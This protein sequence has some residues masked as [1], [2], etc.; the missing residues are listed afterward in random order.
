MESLKI[1]V[2]PKNG[3]VER[4]VSYR[5]GGVEFLDT[6]DVRKHWQRDKS[7]KKAC[8]TL[9]IPIEQ[10]DEIAQIVSEEASKKHFV[11]EEEEL[12]VVDRD[13]RETDNVNILPDHFLYPKGMIGD[14]IK[15]AL[16]TSQYPQPEMCLAGAIALMSVITGRRVVNQHNARTNLYIITVNAARSGKD[17]I[18]DVNKEILY[19]AGAVDMVGPERV[20]S[21]A[22]IISWIDKSPEILFQLDEIGRMLATCRDARSSHLYNVATVLM[23]LFSSAGSMWKADAYAETKKTKIIDQ[24]HCVVFGTTT[25]ETLWPNIS[26][27]NVADGMI[28]RLLI[29]EG[30]GYV[31]WN[32]N[33]VSKHP[34]EDLVK[35]VRFWIEMKPG[36]GAG[37]LETWHPIP[38]MIPYSKDAG[39]RF[40]DHVKSINNKRKDETPFRAAVWSGTAE[41]TAKLALIHACSMS[42]GVPSEVGINDI[43]WAVGI[44]NFLTRKM[45]L[46][47]QEEVSEN[48][49][50]ARVKK[51]LKIIGNSKWT[52]SEL[53]KKLQWLTKRDRTEILNDMIEMRLIEKREVIGKTKH[54]YLY[55]STKTA[56]R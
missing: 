16:E 46:R 4:E 6:F 11:E 10:A 9:R 1:N 22:G 25:A 45:I 21:H 7:A 56:K 54:S 55:F 51:V 53:G 37:N 35:A 33:Y 31:D 40:L 47:C 42:Y 2:A 15:F 23:S 24:P 41:K 27:E 30:R 44:C 20:G 17:R 34:P 8:E 43:E 39:D 32:D 50:E 49:I 19:R 3:E 18:R 52:G 14:V 48:Y 13:I 5:Y 26:M 29:F 28:G 36:S 38:L 12:E